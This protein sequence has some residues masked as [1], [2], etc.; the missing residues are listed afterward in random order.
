MD[1][2][3]IKTQNA[4]KEAF[5]ELRKEKS[6]EKITIK[7][8]CKEAKINKSTFYLHYD[9]IYSLSD[10]MEIDF[11]E[12]IVDSVF[13]NCEFSLENQVMLTRELSMAFIDNVEIINILFS[14]NQQGK[15][16]THLETAVK[17]RIFSL[18]PQYKNNHKLQVLLTYCVQGGYHS[19]LNNHDI[20]KDELVEIIDSISKSMDILFKAV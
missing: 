5:V 20:D 18:Y 6:T 14:G 4:I 3:I 19:Y 10:A 1:A 8:L 2:R 13:K 12:R 7:E 15:F 11:V 9:D 17:N 16:A